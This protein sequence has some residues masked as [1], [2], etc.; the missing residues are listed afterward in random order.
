MARRWDT[1]LLVV[2][3][4]LAGIVPV[5]T[6]ACG[7]GVAGERPLVSRHRL[8]SPLVLTQLPARAEPQHQAAASGGTLRARFGDRARLVVIYPDRSTRILSR[9]FYGACDPDVS[10][11]ATRILFA[12]KSTASDNWNIYEASVDGS[13]I[14]QITQNLGDCRS[15]CYQSTLYSL[16]PVGVP[17]EPEYHVTFVA[18]AG[19]LNEFG[20]CEATCLYSCKLDGSALRRLTFNLSSAMDPTIMSDGRLLFASWQRR[21]LTQ[22]ILGGVGLL[23]VNI[24]G[25]DYALFAGY[26]GRRVKHMPC[27][28]TSGLVVFVE[29]QEGSWD[30]AGCLSCVTVRRPLHSYRQITGEADGLFHSPSPLRD[31]RILVSR[32]PADGSASHGVWRFDPLS[33]QAELLFDDPRYH[34]IQAKLIHPRQ[35]PDGRSSAVSEEQDKSHLTGKF[36]CLSVYTSDLERSWWLPGSVR[37]LRV[38]EG[39]PLKVG[40]KDA[41]LPATKPVGFSAPGPTFARFPGSTVNGIPPLVQRRILGD[42]PLEKDG[43]LNIEVPANTPVEL[44]ILDA[45]G[46]ALRSCGW[47]WVKDYA[48]QGCVGCHEDPE[49]VPENWFVEAL[50]RPSTPLYLPPERRRTVDFRRDVMPIIQQKCVSCHGPG[51]VPPRLDGGLT[52]V[53]HAGGAYFNRAYEGLLALEGSQDAAAGTTAGD[54]GKYVHPGRA[55]TSPLIWHIFGRNTSRAWDGA[56]VRKPVKPIPAENSVPLSDD[57]KRTFV[58]WIDMGAMWDGIPGADNLPGKSATTVGETR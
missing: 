57:E 20:G 41:Y 49:L 53:E 46:L 50:K 37:R 40:E 31:G 5:M 1:P 38:L 17:N 32:R 52:L 3:V 6:T 45:D 54:R 26:Q 22:G 39:V 34:E 13:N 29:P 48:R 47:I 8:N 24:D 33:K 30:G 10:F 2:R 55:R 7:L 15:P 28:T 36:Y 9:G 23:G 21:E 44:Q 56:A 27:A 42:I 51:E 12:G 43:S 11:D 58:E 14:K 18:G 16:K 19:T 25:T 35:E 4:V